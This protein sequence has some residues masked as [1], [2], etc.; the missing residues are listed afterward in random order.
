MKCGFEHTE[1]NESCW[2]F[3]SSRRWEAEP[4]AAL[5]LCSYL[6]VIFHQ[7]NNWLGFVLPPPSRT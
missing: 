5:T 2:F 4:A 3:I 6:H 7:Y 1:Y